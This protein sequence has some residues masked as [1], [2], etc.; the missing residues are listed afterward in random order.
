MLPFRKRKFSSLQRYRKAWDAVKS[1]GQGKVG[2][3]EGSVAAG[4]VVGGT[5]A[6]GV[7][8]T[9]VGVVSAVVGHVLGAVE[10]GAVCRPDAGGVAPGVG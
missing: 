1:S 10:D 9:V 6:T 8:S 3:V 2:C 7:V 4:A 5:V